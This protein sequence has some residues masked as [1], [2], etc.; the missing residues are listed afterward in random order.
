[1]TATLVFPKYIPESVRIEA[2]RLLQV[3]PADPYH[4]IIKSLITREVM[5]ECYAELEKIPDANM[6][7][8]LYAAVGAQ[9][10]LLKNLRRILI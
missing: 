10:N 1:M 2:Q 3:L 6:A 7:S 4:V 9:N 5:R 8:Y